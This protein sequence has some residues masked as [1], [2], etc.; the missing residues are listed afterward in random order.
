MTTLNVKRPLTQSD[1]RAAIGVH[2]ISLTSHAAA[3]DIGRG[4]GVACRRCKAIALTG[5][6]CA[7]APPLPLPRV[8]FQALCHQVYW[9]HSN[10]PQTL[11]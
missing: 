10:E 1:P 6:N 8:T 9:R 3:G 7:V 2:L 11:K 4:G 5:L